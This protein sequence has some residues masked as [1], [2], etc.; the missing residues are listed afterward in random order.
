MDR[1]LSPA[2]VLA[3]Y[4]PHH[5]TISSLLRSR[6]AARAQLEALRFEARSWTYADLDRASDLVA[7]LVDEF[8]VPQLQHQQRENL[9]RNIHPP[10]EVIVEQCGYPLGTVEPSPAESRTRQGVAHE[11]PQLR[12]HPQFHG[13]IE[14]LLG[15]VEDFGG[16]MGLHGLLHEQLTFAIAQLVP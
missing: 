5:D 8:L 15:P 14:T 4:E 3:L 10:G 13:Y 6:C 2:E 12:P 1:Q 9:V 11:I 7:A 16:K